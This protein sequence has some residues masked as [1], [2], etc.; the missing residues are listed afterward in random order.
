MKRLRAS[1]AAL[2]ICTCA[3]SSATIYRR[4]AP[5]LEATIVGGNSKYLYVETEDGRVVQIERSKI[6]DIDHPGNG[7]AVVGG[8]WVATW[9]LLVGML[10]EL[11]GNMNDRNGALVT[12]FAVGILPG[13][14]PL[15]HGIVTWH[16]STSAA[17][18]MAMQLPVR[19]PDGTAIL[20]TLTVPMADGATLL[21]AQ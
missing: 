14:I 11:S 2:V 21:Q 19:R 18:E 15:V 3:C 13:A 16:Q 20:G 17:D 9:S 7:E 12:A 8:L 5:D 10:A 4:D 1:V 6:T